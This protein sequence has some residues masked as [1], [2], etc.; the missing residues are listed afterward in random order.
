MKTK[1]HI[2][3]TIILF[4]GCKEESPV[5]PEIKYEEKEIGIQ[6]YASS[7]WLD[8]IS[9]L[10][11]AGMTKPDYIRVVNH[12]D[13]DT[14]YKSF[15]FSGSLESGYYVKYYF[16]DTTYTDRFDLQMNLQCYLGY[17]IPN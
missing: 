2:F 7:R 10:T 17:K 9:V 5:V 15:D 4:I 6:T 13:R 11:E 14:S 16:S 3:L 12:S 8:F 1:L